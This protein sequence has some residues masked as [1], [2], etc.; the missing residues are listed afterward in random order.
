M[1]A[2]NIAWADY[3]LGSCGGLDAAVGCMAGLLVTH[4]DLQQDKSAACCTALCFVLRCLP[5]LEPR[6]AEKGVLR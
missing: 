5:T 6:V 1:R 2:V 3:V 4:A